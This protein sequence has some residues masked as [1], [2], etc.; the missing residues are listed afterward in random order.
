MNNVRKER[1]QE[2]TSRITELQDK[3]IQMMI[4]VTAEDDI[5]VALENR[6]KQLEMLKYDF[7]C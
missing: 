4:D 3:S 2:V 7:C 1:D 5:K 6:D